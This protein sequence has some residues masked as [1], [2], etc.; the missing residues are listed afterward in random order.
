MRYST[1]GSITKDESVPLVI[2][3]NVIRYL[4]IPA[5]YGIGQSREKKRMIF[6]EDMEKSPDCY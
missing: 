6:S 1:S 3:K 2:S 4:I 5:G